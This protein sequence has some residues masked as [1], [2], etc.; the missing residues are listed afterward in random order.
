MTKRNNS[1]LEPAPKKK[2]IYNKKENILKNIPQVYVEDTFDVSGDNNT[3]EKTETLIENNNEIKTAKIISKEE[4]LK[5]KQFK[6]KV[7]TLVKNIFF[8]K[9]FSELLD[10]TNLNKMYK[11]YIIDET[12][13]EIDILLY[14]VIQVYRSR[15][16]NIV[17]TYDVYQKI[18]LYLDSIISLYNRFNNS[19]NLDKSNLNTELS[20]LYSGER[21]M[22]NNFFSYLK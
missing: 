19:E 7:D 11:A 1:A 20:K 12:T 14:E 16:S 4:L 15:L 22:K 6:N 9:S 21:F 17:L 10:Y 18:N 5:S 2:R 8:N 3:E 13:N